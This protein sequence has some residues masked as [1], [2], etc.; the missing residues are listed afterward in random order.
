MVQFKQVRLTPV[1]PLLQRLRALQA[2][3]VEDVR[4]RRALLAASA[5]AV[6]RITSLAVLIVSVPLT[7]A[8]L[9][10]ERFGVWMLIASLPVL[11]G[12]LDL[13]IGNG[14]LN[15][16]AGAKAEGDDNRLADVISHGLTVLACMGVVIGALALAATFFMPWPVISTSSIPG[17][18]AEI[19]ASLAVFSLLFAASLP[20]SGVQRV[21]TALQ[22]GY[23]PY[24]LTAGANIASLFALVAL[25]RV[26]ASVPVLLLATYGLQLAAVGLLVPLLR[27]RRL[28]RVPRRL[29]EFTRDSKQL[30]ASGG[31]FF[32]LQVGYMVGWG[33]DNLIVGSVL[34]VASVTTL[35]IVSRLYQMVVVPI[36]LINQPLWPA[37]VDALA[38]RDYAWVRKTLSASFAGS[39]IAATVTASIAFAY[40]DT[41]ISYWIGMD[42]A[43]PTD[44]VLTYAIWTVIQC[45]LNSFAMFLNAAHVL[46]P[47]IIVVGLFCLLVLP[48]KILLLPHIGLAAIPLSMM[49]A[50]VVAV[51][52]P[53]LTRFRRDWLHHLGVQTGR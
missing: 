15:Q 44:L 42:S 10:E 49:I 18:E 28:L 3:V 26:Q 39:L 2:K 11:L 5:N 22:E 1:F 13:G 46:V 52:I 21:Y 16:V 40:F 47:Q 32:V 29:D 50:F 17:L 51:I 43:L 31:L 7:L 36:A 53:Y 19:R 27:R 35:S 30:I 6:A 33:A 20:L 38:R 8:Y 45:G 41:I 23:T 37:Y 12:F 48:L 14:L 24:W 4:Y 9:G 34:G 25:S